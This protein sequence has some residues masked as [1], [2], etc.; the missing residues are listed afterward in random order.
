VEKIIHGVIAAVVVE[1]CDPEN[2]RRVRVRLPPP[3]D[4]AEKWARVATAAC[5]A[6]HP[7]T[8][9]KVQD[10]VLVAFDHGDV[11]QP[12]VVG[13]L[14]DNNAPPTPSKASK[15]NLPIGGSL[16]GISADD[17]TSTDCARTASL[18]QQ[19]APWL[20]SMT[21][22]L[23]VLKLL[24]PLIEVIESLP[25]V[26]AAA[27]REFKKEATNLLPCLLLPESAVALPFVREL[28]CLTLR[29]LRCLIE[30]TTIGPIS[31]EAVAPIQGVI[32]LARP[33][34]VT[35]G[36]QFVQLSALANPTP[37]ALQNDIA[38]IEVIVETLGGCGD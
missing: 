16:Y 1:T 10:E 38:A 34:F 6:S 29:S 20:A 9:L 21:C 37:Q 36:I 5:C 15:V 24:K 13:V 19:T 2:R 12:F 28:L 23:G 4:P 27:V 26:S 35:A 18:L 30:G 22:L 32:D 17:N 8:G 31:A 11:N 3:A 14:W 25:T 7:A 33:F